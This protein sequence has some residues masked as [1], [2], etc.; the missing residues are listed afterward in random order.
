MKRPYQNITFKSFK[1]LGEIVCSQFQNINLIYRWGLAGVAA[2][3]AFGVEYSFGID[4]AFYLLPIYLGIVAIYLLVVQAAIIDFYETQKFSAKVM[5]TQSLTTQNGGQA[6]YIRLLPVLTRTDKV[7]VSINSVDEQISGKWVQTN[8]AEAVNLQWSWPDCK[9]YFKTLYPGEDVYVDI[10]QF[11][12]GL[13]DI[14]F[15]GIVPPSCIR[16]YSQRTPIKLNMVI[17]NE[18]GEFFDFSIKIEYV[19]GVNILEA[20]LV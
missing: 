2:L 1:K 19:G 5:T 17:V 18:S 15:A 8:F 14:Q 10:C 7:R 6:R 12:H 3:A 9:A 13:H 16:S 4:K 11:T 20:R